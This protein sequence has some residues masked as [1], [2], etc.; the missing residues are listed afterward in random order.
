MTKKRFR[1]SNTVA[2]NVGAVEVNGENFISIRKMYQTNREPGVWKPGY[3]GVTIPVK[4]I[5]KIA[6]YAIQ[7]AED[8]ETT[9][10][11]IEP[12]PKAEKKEKK[13]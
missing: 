5:Q 11:H 2:F 8:D 1:A 9:F 13:K 10:L 7:I 3:Q 6:G 12:K 4:G